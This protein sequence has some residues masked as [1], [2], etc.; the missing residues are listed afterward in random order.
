[1]VKAN[2][3]EA[4]F[5]KFYQS[6]NQNIKKPVGSGLGL[7]ICKQII[8]HHRGKIWAES[9]MKGALILFTLPKNKNVENS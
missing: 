7:S 5:E 6:T 2:D 3:F 9:S 8:E 4:I 1:M